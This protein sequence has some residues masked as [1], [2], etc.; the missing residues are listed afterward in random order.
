MTWGLSPRA[1]PAMSEQGIPNLGT[2]SKAET[3]GW[4]S[5]A[6]P[7]TSNPLRSELRGLCCQA[8][9]GRAG[10]WASRS[11]FNRSRRR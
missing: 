1:L 5:K 7:L 9:P 11:S 4:V 8:W 10:G 6:P 2:Q 3:R